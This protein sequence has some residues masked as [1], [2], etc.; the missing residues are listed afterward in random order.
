M[1]NFKS[2]RIVLLFCAI[3]P[4]CSCGSDSSQST[5]AETAGDAAATDASGAGV[6][7]LPADAPALPEAQAAPAPGASTPAAAPAGGVQHYTCPK[8][9]KGS[10][11]PTAG[12]CPVCGTAYVHNAAFHGQAAP[13]PGTATPA[14]AIPNPAQPTPS[15][16]KNAAGVYHY[17]CA[18]GCAG[19]A[20]SAGKCATCGGDLAH[21][22]AYHQ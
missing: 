14:G 8:N 9:C 19:G 2:L 21:N 17:T 3:L 15:P 10:G 12:N 6:A 16:A 22:A 13:A 11:G 1:T 20:A 7:P 18:K 5:T 4:F